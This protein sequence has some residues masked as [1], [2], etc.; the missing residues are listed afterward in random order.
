M[1][2][3]IGAYR[4]REYDIYATVTAYRKAK[5]DGAIDLANRIRNAN[6]SLASEFDLVDKQVALI[7]VDRPEG[8][9]S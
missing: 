1:T 7:P 2:I 9:D 8:W 3:P 4:Q 5:E 6:P